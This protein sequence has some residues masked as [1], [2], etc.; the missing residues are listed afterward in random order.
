MLRGSVCGSVCGPFSTT[1]QSSQPSR[2]SHPPPNNHPQ[3]P[4]AAAGPGPIDADVALGL[5]SAPPSSFSSSV[6]HAL[7]LVL[8]HLFLLCASFISH[9]V[10][11]NKIVLSIMSCSCWCW[12]MV[13]SSC[14]VPC[15]HAHFTVIYSSVRC[16]MALTGFLPNRLVVS[17]RLRLP[18]IAICVSISK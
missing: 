5:S 16:T 10:Q 11:C 3:Q 13:V 4:A 18:T 17:L 12:N 2:S 9:V 7:S 8:V 14:D 15:M 6:T 1:P